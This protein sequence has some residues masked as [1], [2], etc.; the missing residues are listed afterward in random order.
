VLRHELFHVVLSPYDLYER[1]VANAGLT[2]DMDRVLGRVW[3]H[4]MEKAVINLER[5][6]H[7]L[8]AEPPVSTTE[9]ATDT[10]GPPAIS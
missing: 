5:A 6:F 2:D 3:T 8:T 10:D 9:P 4:V 1:A 7:G